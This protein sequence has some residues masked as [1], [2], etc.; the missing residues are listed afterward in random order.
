[1]A[2][3]EGFEPS[4]RFCRILTFQASAFDH[5]AT[6][7]HRWRVAPSGAHGLSQVAVAWHAVGMSIRSYVRLAAL[8]LIVFASS[9]LSA[10]QAPGEIVAAAPAEAWNAIAPEDLM[11]IDLAPAGPRAGARRVVVQLM[12]APFSTG[13]IANI[14]ALVAAKWWDGVSVNRVQDNYVVQ[15]GDAL[16][17]KALPPTLRAVAESEYTTSLEE[18]GEAQPILSPVEKARIERAG[19]IAMEGSRSEKAPNGW[20]ERDAYAPW[21][22]LYRGWPIASD[23]ERAWPVHCYATVGVGRNLSPDTGTGAELYAVIGH[24]P[25]HLDRNIGV[26][27][28]VIAGI[29]H[30]SSLPRGTGALGVYERADERVPIQRVRMASSLPETERPRYEAMDTDSEA[31]AR[32]ADARANRRDAFFN[33][34]AGGVDICNLPV[35]VRAVG[36]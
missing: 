9:P 7:P 27:G 36:R 21:V 4:I 15:W 35:P 32:Y 17:T 14:R 24:A 3:R 26:V 29:E 8:S 25:R 11:V 16:E 28:R 34:P 22:E 13:H 1:M 2:E 10:Q 5:S 12:P 31:F 18:L 30:L 33:L 19:E 23:G 6:A 20:H